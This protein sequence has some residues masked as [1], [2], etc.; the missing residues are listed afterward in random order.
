MS[1]GR[2]LLGIDF[3]GTLA[4]LVDDPADSVPDER[5][6]ELLTVLASRPN[7]SVVVVSGRSHLDLGNRLGSVPGV[8]LIGEHGND[9]G[10]E[11]AVSPVVTDAA[12]F[13]HVLRGERDAVIETKSSSVTFHTRRLT[14]GEK[15]EAAE[16]IR[17]WAA[18]HPETTLLQGKEV[19]ELSVA[20]RTKGDAILDLKDTVDGVIYIGDDTTDETVFAVLAPDDVGIKVG[21]GPS[22]A[23][24]R[25]ADV[26]EVVELLEVAALAS[27]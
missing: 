6:V 5:A 25:V 10:A 1:R 3:D 12:R 24:F 21:P 16:T 18:E 27:S 26:S 13:L 8:N 9:T 4:P 11:K 20:D 7:V 22:A 14:D 23:R 19:L 15:R 17:I 2:V